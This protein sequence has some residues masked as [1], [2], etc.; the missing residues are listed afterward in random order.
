MLAAARQA[1]AAQ[2]S[3]I[4]AAL[5][6][7]TALESD[8]T[9]LRV[10]KQNWWLWVFHHKDNA[11]FVAEASRGKCVPQ[12]FLG[13]WRP[14]YWIS[15]RYSAQLGWAAKDNQICLAHLIRGVRSHIRSHLRDICADI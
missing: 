14:D 6:G 4:R 8:E 7:G 15:D 5:M 13:E 1:F 2:T 12:A 11:V 3:R 10:G 9:G